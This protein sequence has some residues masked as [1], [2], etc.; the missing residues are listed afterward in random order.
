MYICIYIYIYIYVYIH[1]YIYIYIYIYILFVYLFINL[2]HVGIVKI[3]LKCGEAKVEQ[4]IKKILN[5]APYR[6]GGSHKIGKRA[7]R[8]FIIIK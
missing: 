3:L 5:D 7:N 2:F 8:D 4:L 6:E 1:I